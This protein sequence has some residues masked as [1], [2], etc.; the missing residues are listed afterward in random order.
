MQCPRQVFSNAGLR[1]LRAALPI[2]VG[3]ALLL[4]ASAAADSSAEL[5]SA[6]ERDVLVSNV[7]GEHGGRLV[8]ALRAEPTT[9]N[10]VTAL[11]N[12]SLTILRRITAD[13]VHVD[14]ATQLPAAALAKSWQRSADGL[15]YILNL[16]RGI[17]FSDGHAFDAEDVMFTFEVLLDSQVGSPHRDFL[18]PGGQA[19]VAEKVDAHTL[20]FQ[21]HRPNAA[22]LRLFDN[23]PI[24]P[25]HRLEEPYRQGRLGEMWGTGSDPK[26]I[27][28][29]GPFQIES[30]VPGEQV[31]LSRNPHYWKVDS[32]GRSLPFLDQLVFVFVADQTAQTLRFQA[33]EV[34]VVDRLKAESFAYL[35]TRPGKTM[36]DLGPGLEYSFLFFNLN[37]L[38]DRP[39]LERKQKWF[40]ED[41][42]RRAISTAIDRQGI[43]GL[44]YAGQ[45]RPLATHVTPGIQQ[46]AQTDLEPTPQ[47]LTESRRILE[48]M[49]FRLRGKRLH[50]AGGLPVEL[51]II[52]TSSN[53]ERLGMA[54]I[55]QEDLRQ[56][57]IGATVVGLEFR[58]LLDRVFNS[59]DYE[60]VVL[61]MNSGDTDPNALIPVLTS[62]G[63]NHLWQLKAG[64]EL[65][66]WQQEI[67]GLMSRQVVT[68][69]DTE[70]KRMY[71][72]VQ[73][74]VAEHLPMIFL[75]SPHVLAGS[76]SALGNFRPTVLGHSTLWNAEELYW[77]SSAGN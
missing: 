62:G 56:L 49:G 47:S 8:V 9:F 54:T 74:L 66:R 73:Q 42:F 7:V 72:R 6:A 23:L 53:Q 71:G 50:D 77:K 12:P 30:Y 36:W 17:R 13:L 21:L 37:H 3:S 15:Q 1:I 4:G 32:K 26:E 51:T 10:P 76:A 20:R 39:D 29:L 24:L 31:V 5:N 38:E 28:G 57:G 60:A 64:A 45:A 55:V 2:F 48:E 35:Q 14:R 61:S 25:K 52:S 58:A 75:V 27:V 44:I 43:A 67:D 63:G 70:R 18:M 69:D 11:D 34:H 68:L 22:G 41:R 40:K 65:P 59:F 19:I 46:W 33:G 16:R